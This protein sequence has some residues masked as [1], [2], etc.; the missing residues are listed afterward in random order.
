MS[1]FFSFTKSENWRAEQ[2]LPGWFGTS[3]G[4]RR[5]KRE[6]EGEYGANTVCTC[7]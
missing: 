3:E 7:I 1:F 4:G 5:W 6:R 2:V